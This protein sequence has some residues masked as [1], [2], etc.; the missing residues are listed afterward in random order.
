MFQRR[1]TSKFAR[2]AQTATISV[3]NDKAAICD[4]H[5]GADVAFGRWGILR[6]WDAV[7]KNGDWLVLGA[8]GLQMRDVLD[9]YGFDAELNVMLMTLSYAGYAGP[10]PLRLE[11]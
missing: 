10:L 9:R 4:L 1:C 6:S 2:V 3:E 8:C 11:G 5:L 7:D